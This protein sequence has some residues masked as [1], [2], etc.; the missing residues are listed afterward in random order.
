MFGHFELPNFFMN[1]M[2]EMPDTGELKG[3]DFVAQEYVFSGHFHKRQ[4]KNNIHYLGNPFPHN[5]ADVDDD[6]RGMMILEYGK[7]PVYFNWGN[8]PKYRNVKLSTL[9]DKTKEIMKSKMHLRVTLDIDISFEEASFI[10]ETFMKEY[11]CREIT[12]IPNKKDEEINTDID[13]TKFESVDQI[14]SKEIESIESDAYDKQ[15][16]LGIFRDLNNDTN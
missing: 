12:L 1:A 15:V 16:L 5:Y 9:L 8:C 10:K 7:E 14:V 11:G 3:S 6:E 4:F 2:V 13:I